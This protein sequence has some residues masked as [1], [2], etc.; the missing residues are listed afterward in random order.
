M[1]VII[2]DNKLEII[3]QPKAIYFHLPKNVGNNLEYEIDFIIKHSGF[4]G[5]HTIKIENS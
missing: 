1:G 4:L 3:T 2:K 5:G